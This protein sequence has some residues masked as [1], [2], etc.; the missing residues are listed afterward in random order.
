VQRRPDDP[1]VIARNNTDGDYY[2]LR[3]RGCV[4]SVVGSFPTLDEAKVA[5]NW[6]SFPDDA[7]EAAGL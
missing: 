4:R 1:D 3:G 5:T 2:V 7:G 6:S